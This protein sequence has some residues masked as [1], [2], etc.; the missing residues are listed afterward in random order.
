MVPGGPHS[1]GGNEEPG[2]ETKMGGRKARPYNTGC[3]L[4][5]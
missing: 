1:A 4:R 2:Q 5:S 3:M